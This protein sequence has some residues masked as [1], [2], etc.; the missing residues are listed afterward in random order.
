MPNDRTQ[1]I[2]QLLQSFQAIKRKLGTHVAVAADETLRRITTSQWGVLRAVSQEERM[3]TKDIATHLCISSSAATQLVDVLVEHG[4]LQR[5]DHPEDRRSQYIQLSPGTKK[6]LNSLRKKHLTG[7]SEIFSILSDKELDQ[8][9]ELSSR[10]A[11]HL[12][13]S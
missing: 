8:Y 11:G 9:I 7:L 3:T 6:Q 4:H 1:K 5:F 10:I 2:E 12:T 13:H